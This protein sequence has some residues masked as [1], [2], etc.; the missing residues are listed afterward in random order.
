MRGAW[1]KAK[2]ALYISL[3]PSVWVLVSRRLQIQQMAVL[4]LC[5]MHFKYS[6]NS[7][8]FSYKNNYIT[9]NKKLCSL[10][11]L[12]L[13]MKDQK[14]R[15][16]VQRWD[17]DALYE[18]KITHWSF[19]DDLFT[20]FGRNMDKGKKIGYVWG[21]RGRMQT[22]KWITKLWKVYQVLVSSSQ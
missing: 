17:S 21:C 20:F 7:N 1:G 13:A 3:T 12:L 6:F 19:Y 22:S 8:S 9:K 11:E 4:L 15:D 18:N 14:S 16:E 2:H 10:A 5:S